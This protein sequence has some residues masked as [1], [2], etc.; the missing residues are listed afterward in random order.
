MSWNKKRGKRKYSQVFLKDHSALY[1][2]TNAVDPGEDD[3]VIEIG[4]G[5][6]ALTKYLLKKSAKVVAIE[7]DS[8]MVEKLKDKFR[9]NDK[10]EIVNEDILKLDL[11]ALIKKH[12][13]GTNMFLVGNLP[14]DIGTAIIMKAAASR[15]SFNRMVFMLQ[16]EVVDRLLA[17]PGSRSYGYISVMMDYYFERKKI[18]NVS[19]SSFS[20]RPAVKSAVILLTG[21]ETGDSSKY[22]RAFISFLKASFSQKRKTLLNNLS[23]YPLLKAKSKDEIKR[24]IL[25][26]FTNEKIRGEQ[27]SL[28]EFKQIFGRFVEDKEIKI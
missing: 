28:Y 23:G 17:V 6:G 11:D 1:K 25:S 14:Y 3:I 24:L 20:P 21:K 10:L 8:E 27:I 5:K 2:I 9:D 19:P 18:L 13:T 22:E 4:P 16:R 12:R 7:I 15:K 26:V